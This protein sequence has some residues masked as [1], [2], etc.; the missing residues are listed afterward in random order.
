MS[1]QSLLLLSVTTGAATVRV[2]PTMERNDS[3][4]KSTVRPSKDEDNRDVDVD[5][6]VD[7]ALD[8]DLDNIPKMV[9]PAIQHAM[10]HENAVP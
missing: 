5:N 3:P 4:T 1:C 10:K 6:V 9:L 7:F 2:A 8:F